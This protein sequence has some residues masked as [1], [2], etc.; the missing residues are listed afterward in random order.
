MFSSRQNLK[1]WRFVT[2]GCLT[3]KII[4]NDNDFVNLRALLEG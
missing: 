4:V 3:K 2:E 1:N